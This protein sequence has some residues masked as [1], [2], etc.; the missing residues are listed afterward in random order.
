MAFDSSAPLLRSPD[1]IASE[2][3][4]ELV[5]VSIQDGKYFGL[6]AVGSEI[7]RLLEEPRS[8]AA[9]VEALQSQFEGDAAQVESDTLAFIDELAANGLLRAA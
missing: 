3:D 8:S 7:W 1:I 4:G 5:L 6:D 9:L 2:V